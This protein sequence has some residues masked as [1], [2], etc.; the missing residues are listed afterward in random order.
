MQLNTTKT[1][2]A[3]RVG[4]AA[5][6]LGLS[7]AG[8]QAMGI[9]SADSPDTDSASVSGV[10]APSKASTAREP[11]ARR[12]AP[13]RT[14]RAS[15][16]SARRGAQSVEPDVAAVPPAV[17]VADVSQ[18][19]TA[20]GRGQ[21]GLLAPDAF[22]DS[23]LP[24]PA[25]TAVVESRRSSLPVLAAVDTLAADP[26]GSSQPTPAAAT[27]NDAAPPVG[28]E[29]MA[30]ASTAMASL[31]T[32]PALAAASIPEPPAATATPSGVLWD[33]NTAVVSVFDA[34]QNWLAA[35]PANPFSDLLEGALLLVRRSLFNQTPTVAPVQ[36]KTLVTGQI[37]GTFGAVDP[38]GD[39]LSY[40][41]T[42]IPQQGNVQ[43]NPD[44]TY[45]Y[46]PGPDYSGADRFTVAVNDGGFNILNPS[47]SWRPAQAVG[48][49]GDDGVDPGGLI[50]RTL[51]IQNLTGSALTL[52][53][54]N[55]TRTVN[56]VA[57]IGTVLQPGE[58]TSVTLA[59]YVFVDNDSVMTFSSPDGESSRYFTVD[60]NSA[61]FD[62]YW[63]CRGSATN[64]ETSGSPTSGAKVILLDAPGTVISVPSGQG[65][66]QADVLN[67]LCGSSSATCTYNPKSFDATAYTD[68]KLA[69]DSVSNNTSSN[70]TTT[71]TVTTSRSTTTGLKL[72]TSAKG[73]VLGI[74]EVAV[75]AE[76]SETWTN[77]YTFSQAI[78]V[79]AQPGEKVSVE[80]RD[81]VKRVTGDFTLVMRNTTWKLYD[82]N[83]DSPDADRRSEYKA[84]TTPI[85]TFRRAGE[86]MDPDSSWTL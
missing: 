9:A 57:P 12:S 52:S 2:T 51:T 78:T 19:V 50:T 73:S 35:L 42:G 39:T 54:F 33:I 75:T 28:G 41:L 77:T 82:V 70:L 61:P 43:I 65:Q 37:E 3:A 48:R 55:A 34:T 86:D 21:S 72:T 29:A 79:T 26:V 16:S 67:Q 49:V 27:E 22:V 23:G 76:A 60:F 32:P 11:V 1:K 46:T 6:A 30:E 25:A 68:W 20:T 45:V 71:I 14:G 58:S 5:V 10:T 13:E 56:N 59:K 85:P 74:V 62:T 63:G 4:A 15:A 64:C 66:K 40:V 53:S 7:L 17:E 8:P 44:G 18:P 69:S 24:D 81:P 84:V 47:G 36:I 31:P 80:S 83:F 38:E